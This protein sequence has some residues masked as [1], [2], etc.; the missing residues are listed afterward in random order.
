M[1]RIFGALL[2]VIFLAPISSYAHS[3]LVTSNPKSGAA[4][5]KS[6]N[7]ISLT[8]NENLIKIAGKNVSR[9]SLT[10]SNNSVIKLGKT[11]INKSRITAKIISALKSGNY[12]IRFR[13]V[14]SDGH[15]I[16]G[17]IKFSIK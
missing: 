13:V 11:N 4:L 15:P 8:F 7:S 14:S 2:L 9:L 17:A 6:P 16:S 12:K 10:D 3:T 1:K 5:S